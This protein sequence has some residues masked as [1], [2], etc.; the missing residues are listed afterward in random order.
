MAQVMLFFLPMSGK[1]I[2]PEAIVRRF[3]PVII[4]LV[5]AVLTLLLMLPFLRPPT[6]SEVLI[7]SDL[8][9]QQYPLYSLI[10]DNVRGGNGL[11]LWNSYQFVGQSITANPQA[12][13]VYPP[14]WL[15]LVLGV[16]RG[17][18]WLLILHLWWGAWGMTVF[19]QALGANRAGALLGGVIYLLSGVLT[20]HLNAGH[21]NYILCSAWIPWL[22][23][24]YLR[25]L[26]G[27]RWFSSALAG[28]AALGMCIL[29]GHPPMFYFGLILLA[30]LWLY[31]LLTR[32]S[33]LW[34]ASRPL[35]VILAAGF[36][37]GAALLLPVAEFTPRS[38][39]TEASL[40]FSNSYALPGSQVLTMLIPNLF[41][42]PFRGYWGL[43]FYEELT[44]YIGI[45]PLVAVLLFRRRPAVILLV[46]FVVIGLVISLGIDGGLFSLLY[47]LLP[48]YGLFRVPPR[49][50][51]S[52]VLGG[53]G[54][55]ALLITDLQA[56]NG[57]ERTAFLRLALRWLPL[58]GLLLLAGSFILSGYF[59]ALALTNDL[60]G[61]VFHAANMT[62]IAAVA[63]G[64]TW[65]A[66]RLWPV[67]GRWAYGVTLLVLLIDLW[68]IS[69]PLVQVGAVDVTQPWKWLSSVQQSSPDYRV[70]TVPDEITLQAGAAYTHHLNISGYD[71]LVSDAYQRLLDA[72]EDNPLSPVSRL[73][74][75]RYVVSRQSVGSLSLVTQDEQDGWQL[76]EVPEGVVPRVFVVPTVEVISEDEAARSRLLELGFNPLTRAIVAEEPTCFADLSSESSGETSEAVITDY[77]PNTVEITSRSA[78]GGIL[79]LT[80]SYD[81]N[82]T[83]MVDDQPVDLL[84]AYTALRGVCV[85]AGEHRVK[86]VYQPRAFYAGIVI[87]GVSWVILGVLSV[88]ILLRRRAVFRAQ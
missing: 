52:V 64:G 78:Q 18:G 68:R 9:N 74:G 30:V 66:L 73:L 6:G 38:T 12:T 1:C 36:L 8:V 47:Y 70:M 88:V 10:F 24:L 15:M 7:G 60:Q 4:P 17:V 11:P 42:E 85:P 48:G 13:I 32:Q 59:S 83:V 3:S 76:Y 87:S 35:G 72:G 71:P 26:N 81:P 69:A 21:L 46:V 49:A 86:F 33:S 28:A 50:L 58:C 55:T 14:A 37:L 2:L 41:G 29:A 77:R 20:A 65:L 40:G 82:W 19:A 51:Y 57:E 54:L 23:G 22:G 75:V 61:R 79:V 84:R 67:N 63:V 16:P 43:P 31:R 25:S 80:D 53:A 34:A 62:L 44:G 56:M 5:L 45:L 27:Q 39:R